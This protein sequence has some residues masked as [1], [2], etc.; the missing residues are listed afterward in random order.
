M[1]GLYWSTAVSFLDSKNSRRHLTYD[2]VII[3]G[4]AGHPQKDVSPENVET[5]LQVVYPPQNGLNNQLKP[6]QD[7]RRPGC[8]L[9][10]YHDHEQMEYLPPLQTYLR[11]SIIQVRASLGFAHPTLPAFV[12]L[13][14]LFT[15]SQ[16]I[17]SCRLFLLGVSSLSL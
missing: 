16:R 10:C 7:N 2:I 8:L 4:G 3:L 5:C 12:S 14:K 15:G 9:W 17:L 13:T 6:R 11:C 1:V